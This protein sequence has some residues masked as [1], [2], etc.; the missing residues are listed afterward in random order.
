MRFNRNYTAKYMI[1]LDDACPT[2]KSEIWGAFEI[3]LDDVGIKPIVGVIPDNQDR[4]LMIS[5]FDTKFWTRI[6]C[7]RDKG[8]EIVMHGCHHVCHE[9]PVGSKALLSLS[10]KSEF[11][12]LPLSKQRELIAAG[13]AIMTR[14]GVRPRAFMAPIHTFDSLTLQALREITDIRI[15]TDGHALTP[16]KKEEFTWIPQQLWH[17]R[18]MPYGVWCICLH[19][20]TMGWDEFHKLEKI[21]KKHKAKFIDFDLALGLTRTPS[22]DD[23]LFSQV[24]RLRSFLKHVLA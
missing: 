14:A 16:F 8:W 19:P 7:W 22:V 11:V 1:R 12:G 9:I 3:L 18:E 20:N 17:F 24:Y 6:R 5:P 4:S 21:I 10:K 2:M 13:Y 23:Y 15:I